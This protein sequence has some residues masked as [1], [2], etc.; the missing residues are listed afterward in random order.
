MCIISLCVWF[1]SH[2]DECA[3]FSNSGIMVYDFESGYSV[4]EATKNICCMKD[5]D[6]VDHSTVIRWFKKFHS[7]CEN[8]DD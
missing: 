8:L 7:G 1:E 4:V 6:T 2:T 5:E 3:L